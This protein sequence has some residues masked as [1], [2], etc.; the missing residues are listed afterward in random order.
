MS[1]RHQTSWSRAMAYRFL[2]CVVELDRLREDLE[3]DCK[4]L[5][6]WSHRKYVVTR[7]YHELLRTY[8]SNCL[9]SSGSLHHLWA[10]IDQGTRNSCTSQ[11]VGSSEDSPFMIKT[12]DGCEGCWLVR[13]L[14]FADEMIEQDCRNN[15][16]WCFRYACFLLLGMSFLMFCWIL[17]QRKEV[18]SRVSFVFRYAV[19]KSLVKSL[20]HLSQET[21]KALTRFLYD[22]FK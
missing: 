18:C 20:G 5:N 15:T 19:R 1:S 9:S 10:C 2:S 4:N 21:R 8:V 11:N 14:D 17:F 22:E 7:F 16:A 3:N 13:E 12:V 6:A